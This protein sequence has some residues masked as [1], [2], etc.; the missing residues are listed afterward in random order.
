MKTITY[1]NASKKC[2][3]L[4][5]NDPKLKHL[6][7]QVKSVT[8]KI[9]DDYYQSLLFT[10]LSQQ[11]SSKVATVIINRFINYYEGNPLPEKIIMTEDEA[12]RKIG[13][14]YQKISYVKSLSQHL[15]DKTVDFNQI[16]VMTNQEIKDMLIK[17]KGI[18]PWSID[19]FL[20]FSLGREDVFSSLDLGLRNAVKKLYQNENLSQK[21]IEEMSLKWKPYRSI[22]S[23]YL[24][25][26]HD[27]N[28]I[29]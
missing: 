8:V 16:E 28:G 24:W 20:M 26:M 13:L 7:D 14:S 27:L 15:L 29:K 4:I 17:V 19:M 9:D 21:E 1:E 3:L 2:Q 5:E 25:H 10:I 12:L 18:G 11:L 6:F 22:V 23:H